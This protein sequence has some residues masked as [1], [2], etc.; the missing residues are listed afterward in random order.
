MTTLIST[1]ITSLEH[2]HQMRR[3][4]VG[5]SEVAALFGVHDFI[6]GYALAARKLGELADQVDEAVLRRGR[7]LEPVARQMIAEAYPAWQLIPADA[8]YED[9]SIRFGC[10][11]DLFVQNER[12]RGV[13]Q[14]KTVHPSAFARKW[15]NA[16][17]HAVE[18]PLW[19]AIQ[20]MCEQHLTGA[21]FAIVAAM[22]I[23][24]G[25]TLEVV[26]VPY[27]PALIENA[28]GRVF[29]F[30]EMVSQ[31]KLPP[32]DYGEDKKHLAAVYAVDD[33]SELDL[34]ADNQLPEIVDR[35]EA[36]KAARQTADDGIAE[37]QAMILHRLGHAASARFAG[38]VIS[39]K[40]VNRKAYQVEAG[41]Y[42]RL[43]IKHD[44][45]R[46][47]LSEDAA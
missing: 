36:L 3:N 46:H 2:W 6:T 28:R 25:L 27:L 11:P 33:G 23:D 40:T 37:A 8:Y 31:G 5:C 42:R 30:W 19:V 47:A 24:Y 12:G 22:V 15:H 4:N 14:I 39:Y 43:S 10:T 20:A 32:P 26:D 7:L 34:T 29:S 16:D 21:D 9:T 45:Q 35:L 44:R 18:P 13:V 1:P 41:S 38:G 17:T